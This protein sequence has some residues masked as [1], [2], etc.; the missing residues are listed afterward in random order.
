MSVVRNSSLAAIVAAVSILSACGGGGGGSSGGSDSGGTTAGS[1]SSSS[2]SSSGGG[3]AGTCPAITLSATDAASYTGTSTPMQTADYYRESKGVTNPKILPFQAID[4]KYGYKYIAAPAMP[5]WQFATTDPSNGVLSSLECD[6]AP[7]VGWHNYVRSSGTSPSITHSKVVVTGGRNAAANRIYTVYNGQQLTAALNEGGLEPKI[8]RVVGHIDLRYSANNTV[9]KEYI[10]YTD[11]KF[12]GSIS[13][14]S[15]TTLVGINDAS[16]NPARITGTSILIGGELGSGTDDPE[17]G[18]KAWIAAGNDG[19]LYPT[20]TRNVIVRNLK[21][22]TPWDV[23]PEDS[24]NGYADGVTLSRAQNIWIDH[25]SITDGDTPDSMASDTRHDGALDIVRGSDYVTL[26]NTF[27]GDHG[28]LT[29]VGN[30]DSGRAWSDQD[31][32]HT[33]FTGLWWSG[34]ASRHPLIRFGQLHTFNNLMQGTSNTPTYGHQFA[35]GLDVRYNASVFSENNFHL[36]TGLKASELCGKIIGGK[37]GTGFRTAGNYFISDTEDGKAW[38]F[39]GPVSVDAAM[40]LQTK[41]ISELPAADI[42]W[43]VPYTYSA[44]CAAQAR[45]NIEINAGA[46]RIGLNAV[47]GTSTDT[48][49]SNSCYETNV[50]SGS[51]SSSSSS[52]GGASSSSSSSSSS[53]GGTTTLPAPVL[54]AWSSADYA[55]PTN[56]SL[57]TT[58]YA[59]ATV[60]GVEKP[61][62]VLNTSA[63]SVT[64]DANGVITIP[65][66][67]IMSFGALASTV[68]TATTTP[69]GM[70]SINNKACTLK[71][72][73]PETGIGTTTKKFQ[74]MVDNNTDSGGNSVHGS[75]SRF[76]NTAAN[77]ITAQTLS[78]PL[79]YATSGFTGGSFIA[80]RTESSVTMKISSIS[81]NCI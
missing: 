35:G 46:G 60:E 33:T 36:F 58:G 29:L 74:I 32:L 2:S 40:K 12:G 49:S 53:S 69:G 18:F 9:F 38:P 34:V 1:S 28:K 27:F 41:C 81:L 16:G 19:D 76:Y 11:Q 45:R 3:S 72:V 21:I 55:I 65:P 75:S 13:I 61:V 26:S 52:S 44:V 5:A 37:A 31:R 50:Y 6:V 30:G 79:N 47:L 77:T 15:N 24:G 42:A 22:D 70:F 64:V 4:G 73:I 62:F 80:F 48:L 71:V 10:S 23:D 66:S 56:T 78:F 67:T 8:V 14:P 59:K 51:S 57:F 25:L 17:A 39:A 43:T 63:S 7:D 20:W 68:T 54:S